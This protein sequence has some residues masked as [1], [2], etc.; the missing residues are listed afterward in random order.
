MPH[1]TIV[2]QLAT[3]YLPKIALRLERLFLAVEQ[4]CL[5]THPIIHHYALKNIIEIIKLIE[6]PELKSRFVKELI[7]VE[8]ALPKAQVKISDQHYAK[9]YVQIQLLNHIA[10]RFGDEIHSNSFLQSI[11]IAQASHTNDC[12]SH[13]PQLLLWLEND[14]NLRKQDLS[15]WLKDLQLLFDTVSI[16]LALI[17]D[18]ANYEQIELIHGFYQCSLPTKSPC[19]VILLKMNK[20]AELFPKMQIG[21]HGL[22]LRLCNAQTLQ[23]IQGANA[24]LELAI[25]QL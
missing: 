15:S 3:G 14:A 23:E 13:A 10:G 8:H 5:E 25:C 21:H 1:D 22:T 11:R 18:T 9:L 24:V 19:H 4:S 7:R 6:K 16:Y 12:E 2:F 20:D 17:R